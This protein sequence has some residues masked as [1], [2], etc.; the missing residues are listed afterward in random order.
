MDAL[1]TPLGCKIPIYINGLEGSELTYPADETTTNDMYP[2]QAIVAYCYDLSFKIEGT[3]EDCLHSFYDNF[4]KHLLY[5]VSE[6]LGGGWLLDRN[7]VS[8]TGTVSKTRP[9]ILGWVN[10]NLVLVG[11]EKALRGELTTARNELENKI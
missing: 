4:V 8:E 11:E 7:R 1:R 3:S 10:N 2:I 9:D 5:V 6:D